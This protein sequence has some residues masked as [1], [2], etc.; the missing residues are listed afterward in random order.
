[1]RVAIATDNGQVAA[2]FGRC[3]SYTIAE[4]EEGGLMEQRQVPNPGHEPGRIPRF[5]SDLGVQVIVSGGMGQRA[6]SLF[7]SLGIDALIGVSGPVDAAIEQL[8][9]GDLKAGGSPCDHGHDH[10]HGGG[11]GDCGHH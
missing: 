8:A 6:M 3:P 7:E 9:K 4:L 11:H 5:L 2:H 1:M 10:G